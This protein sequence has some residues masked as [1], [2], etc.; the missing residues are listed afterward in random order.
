LYTA[1]EK[2]L[3]KDPQVYSI[4]ACLNKSCCGISSNVYTRPLLTVASLAFVVTFLSFILACFC[5]NLSAKEKSTQTISQTLQMIPTVIFL[6]IL[7]GGIFFV[8]LYDFKS[9]PKK[10]FIVPS[11]GVTANF[12]E[13]NIERDGT[14]SHYPGF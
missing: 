2:A 13:I 7:I 1:W 4:T 14:L 3:I 11:L 12:K 8:C 9:L 5:L 6:I 10:D